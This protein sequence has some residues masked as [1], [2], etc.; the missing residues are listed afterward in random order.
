M[1]TENTNQDRELT[2][3]EA[4]AAL[5][6]FVQDRLTPVT[7]PKLVNRVRETFDPGGALPADCEAWAL[8]FEMALDKLEAAAIT[9]TQ[10][11]DDFITYYTGRGGCSNC[12]GTPHTTTCF[13]GRFIAARTSR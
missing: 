4:G 3:D 9:E 13:V 5:S 8:D 10:I 6:R 7:L 12:G 2:G 1:T 11:V